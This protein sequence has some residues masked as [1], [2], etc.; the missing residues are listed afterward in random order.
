MGELGG[1]DQWCGYVWGIASTDQFTPVD[2]AATLVNVS[3]KPPRII[4]SIRNACHAI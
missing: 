2:Y 1:A 4:M 3:V